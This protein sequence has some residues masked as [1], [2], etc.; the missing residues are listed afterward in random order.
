M[1]VRDRLWLW[2]HPERSHNGIY[3]V[4]R[5][6]RITPVEACCYLGIKNAL[7]VRYHDY[8]PFPPYDQYA[9][10]L[11]AL[12]RVVWS[13][14]GASGQTDD[15]T[16]HAVLDLARGM[17]NLTGVMMDD[18]FHGLAPD[19]GMT[20]S[21]TREQLRELRSRLALPD[22]TLDLWVVVYEYMMADAM[23]PHLDLCDV[24]TFWTWK[25]EELGKL[26]S[27]F[28]RFE[29]LAQKQRKVLGCYLYDYGNEG[30][31]PLELMKKQSEFGLKMLRAGRIEG[32]IFLASCICD[33]GLD[34]V[35]WL[36]G[37]VR[38]VG[39]EPVA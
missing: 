1:T 14:V 35:E 4:P 27:N 5:D 28:A 19:G 15:Q 23:R 34:T 25:S 33:I 10:P 17:P 29:Q 22:R 6:S 7:M 8:G 13:V 39:E 12:D 37:W 18:F 30:L 2:C 9:L 20:A 3:G 24:A 38:E 26:E 21:L 11:R 36:R 31:M 16:R 32:M